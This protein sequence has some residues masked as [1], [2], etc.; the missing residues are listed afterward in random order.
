MRPHLSNRSERRNKDERGRRGEG[1]RPVRVNVGVN[2]G[3]KSEVKLGIEC[4]VMVEVI[5]GVMVVVMV[6]AIDLQIW[7]G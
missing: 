4:G 5:F 7:M 2:A 6:G 1:R 3:V